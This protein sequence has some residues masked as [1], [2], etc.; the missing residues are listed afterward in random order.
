ML[1]VSN[2]RDLD[3]STFLTTGGVFSCLENIGRVGLKAIVAEILKKRTVS[4]ARLLWRFISLY[5][6][7]C[8]VHLRLP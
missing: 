4:P 8:K 1:S 2:E 7:T 5:C 6:D 3:F